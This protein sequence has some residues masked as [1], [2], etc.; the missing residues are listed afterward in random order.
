MARTRTIRDA[1]R[2]GYAVGRVRVLETRLL[3]RSHFERL[4]D[5]RSFEDQRRVLSE[6]VYGAYLDQARTAEDVETALDR[7]LA[8]LY[9][10]FL[11]T[12]NLPAEMVAYFRT[13]HDFEN[14][15]GRLKAELLDI[16]AE[17]LLN[18]LGTI[19]AERF[20]GGT[21]PPA[22]VAAE[23][24][25]RARAGAA[26]ELSPDA[27]DAAVD[28]ERFSALDA[29]ARDSRNPHIRQMV[30]VAADLAN[31]KAFVRIRTLGRPLG[32]I[33]RHVV[34]GGT[35]VPAEFVALGRVPLAEALA[36]LVTRPTLSGIDPEALADPA[37]FDVAADAL[38][39]RH[40]HRARMVAVGPE[41][42]VAYVM[43]RKVEA[44]MIRTLLIGKIAG[45][46]RD[47][48]RVRMRDV[49]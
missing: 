22:L 16:P 46:E 17:E 48:L 20:A 12:A 11:E 35:I 36:R 28:I 47:V 38:I 13:M 43:Q 1:I 18:D 9:N 40:L 37:R 27:L 42:V 39:S 7:A 33:E 24:A 25:I 6:T 4:L 21:M 32:D 31:V 45:V 49:A 5:A 14:L 41:P 34:P 3:K 30:R 15:R 23:A 19:P 26:G 10:D 8:D 44:A 29:I 2:F